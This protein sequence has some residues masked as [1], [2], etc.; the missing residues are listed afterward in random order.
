MRVLFF[1]HYF[2]PESN[3]PALRTYEHCRHWVKNGAEVTVITCAPNCPD[4]KLYKNYKNRVFQTEIIDGIKVIRVWTY[5]AANKGFVK[6]VMNFISY[7]IMAVFVAIFCCR[8]IDIIVA[9]SPQFFCGWAG[10]LFKWLRRKPLI[11]EI[12][13]IWPESILAVGAL[14]RNFIFKFLEKLELIMYRSASKIVTVGEGYK[15]EIIKKGIEKEKIA[16]ILNGIDKKILTYKIDYDFFGKFIKKNKNTFI[17]SYIGTVGM[18]HGLQVVIDAAILAQE[19]K[20]HDIIFAIVGSGA[21]LKKLKDKVINLNLK[22]VIFTDKIPREDIP[23]A[24]RSSDAVLVHLRNTELFKTVIPSKIFEIMAL[25]KPI[26]M[27]VAGE[28][29]NI[30]NKAHAG[31]AIMPESAESL[32]DGINKIKQQP[33]QFIADKYYIFKNYSREASAKKMQHIM[34]MFI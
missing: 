4:G 9:T 13:D 12:R 7:M 2:S 32:L 19:N 11:L 28:A 33:Q 15:K 25:E 16:V 14:K 21:E 26:L 17:C 34:E 31:V 5:L 1:S 18:A 27:G 24:I 6:R 10:V 22:N 29:L 20:Q 8:K 23:S 30:V 3:A